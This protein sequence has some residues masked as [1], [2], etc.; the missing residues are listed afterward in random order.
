MWYLIATRNYETD[1][2]DVLTGDSGLSAVSAMMRQLKDSGEVSHLY[3]YIIYMYY[4]TINV[5]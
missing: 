2:N 1:D 4:S 3:L 5:T